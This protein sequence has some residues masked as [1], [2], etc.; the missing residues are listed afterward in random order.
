MTSLLETN[1]LFGEIRSALAVPHHLAQLDLSS[2][3]SE[4]R[5]CFLSRISSM[6]P[7]LLVP[8]TE[9]EGP[10]EHFFGRSGFHLRLCDIEAIIWS[11]LS[12]ESSDYL[13]HMLELAS[14]NGSFGQFLTRQYI[15]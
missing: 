6:N 4:V 12:T 14:I 1:L 8:Y 5:G 3:S 15:T 2:A 9:I 7:E 13:N 11:Q 10:E